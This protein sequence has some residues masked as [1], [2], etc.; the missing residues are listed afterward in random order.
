[1]KNEAHHEV[2]TQLITGITAATGLKTDE[3]ASQLGRPPKAD[4]GDY[5]FPC[6]AFAKAN[7]LNPQAAAQQIAD[8]LNADVS[9]SAILQKAETAGA[10]LN[11]RLKPGALCV[12]VIH[13][14]R[15]AHGHYGESSEGAGKTIVIDYSAPNIAKPFHV[16]HL[17]ST[18][19]G[20][21]LAKIFRALGY[22][23]V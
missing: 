8:K 5:A 2:L 1:M 10:F 18:I 3:V 15:A 4:M 6:F 11:I 23:V 19:I 9:L 16:G 7:K 20:S 21:S 13:A 14:I 17:M 22:T 12:S